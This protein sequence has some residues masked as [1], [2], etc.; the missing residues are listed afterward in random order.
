MEGFAKLEAIQSTQQPT[1]VLQDDLP[2]LQPAR[3]VHRIATG[4]VVQGL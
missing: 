1:V 3:S 4:H 2:Q